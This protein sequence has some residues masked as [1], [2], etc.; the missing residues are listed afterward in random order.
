MLQRRLTRLEKR[1]NVPPEDR[2]ISA[3]EMQKAEETTVE[4]TRIYHRATSLHLDNVG[5]AVNKS[6]ANPLQGKTD[7]VSFLWPQKV[8]TVPL[9]GVR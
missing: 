3:G 8:T 2:H 9:K 5:R 1:L 7:L 4:G 6:T